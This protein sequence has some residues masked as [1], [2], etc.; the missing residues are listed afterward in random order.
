MNVEHCYYLHENGELIAKVRMEGIEADFRESPFVKMFWFI[1]TEDRE[2]AWT[3]LVEALAAGA[4]K[5]RVMDL[6]A[7]WKCDDEDADI[8]ADRI[9]VG[10]VRDGKSWCAH[11][12][13]FVNLQESPAGF[14][15]TKLEAL[16]DLATNLD[17]VPQKMWGR[18]FKELCA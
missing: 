12:K 8:Y 9:G 15:D 6:A 3:L 17:Y 13:D 16:A 10:I 11:L 5:E 14:G 4:K 18:S 7:K 1:D 2:T